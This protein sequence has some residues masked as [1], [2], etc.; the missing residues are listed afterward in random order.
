M[1]TSLTEA[2]GI[3]ILEA[4]CAGLYVVSTR[5]G[6]IPEILPEDMI[7]FA[8]PDEDGDSLIWWIR[9]PF[10]IFPQ[11]FFE[12]F[13][14]QYGSFLKTS[15]ILQRRTGASANSIAGKL[16]QSAQKWFTGK[17][18]LARRSTFGTAFKSTSHQQSL[19]TGPDRSRSGS[20][21]RLG[22]VAG[23]IFCIILVVGCLFFQFLEW[24]IPRE[25]LDFVDDERADGDLVFDR[26]VVRFS[27]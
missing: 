3:A 25:H 7:S 13:R 24:F 14:M 27:C 5:V 16:L 8:N 9:S 15:M 26:L 21:L 19:R 6:G 4:A 1:N 20:T 18:T 2:F 17:C 10:L 23:P 12:P 11:M 22:T